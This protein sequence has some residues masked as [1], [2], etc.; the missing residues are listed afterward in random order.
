M[1][2]CVVFWFR[3]D[4]RIQD[5]HGLFQ[6]LD[7][8]LPVLPIFIFEK[9]ILE[10]LQDPKDLRIK[11]IHQEIN[12]LN[13]KLHEHGSALMVRHG[14]SSTCI[15]D[16]CEEYEAKAVFC[17]E[18]YEPFAISRDNKV[19][20][21]LKA[22]GINF[23][24]FKDQVVFS[25]HEIVKDNQSPYLVYTP[26]S[27][28]WLKK[29]SEIDIKSYHSESRLNYLQLKPRS[30]MKLKEIGFSSEIST[31]P[32]YDVNK[33]A[34]LS[35]E[36]HRNYPALK[37]TTKLSVHLRFGTISIRQLVVEAREINEVFLK[38]LIWREFFMSILF[39]FPRVVKEN[40]SKKFNG[41]NWRNNEDEFGKWKRGETGY[42]IVDA[43]MIELNSTGFM[44]NRVR[45][46]CASFLCKHLLIDWKWGE[47]YFAE[48][49]ID[50]ELS[51]NNGNWQWCAGTGVDAS[52]Y[53]RVFN[54]H[55]QLEKFDPD[56]KYV[57]FWLEKDKREG[58]FQEIV[59]HKFARERAI[60]TYKSGIASK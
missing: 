23:Y 34:I 14:Q 27:K 7:S 20:E 26:Y 13:H 5:N 29:L 40:F 17:N 10:D 36:K 38:E 48:K 24:S 21:D 22:Q 57:N 51:S 42:P 32:T 16:I 45:M 59:E 25:P 4:L 41:I 53:F 31:I 18:D 39:F 55:T 58:F 12:K 52:P 1:K 33:E 60:S 47:A 30:V 8:G 15:Q 43:G 9:S 50:Y 2:G 46:V 28:K 19:K 54:P 37:G 49:L 35:Y 44:H 3:R 6:A 56:R 11:F